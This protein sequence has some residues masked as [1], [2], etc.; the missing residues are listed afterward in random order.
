MSSLSSTDSWQRKARL[1]RWWARAQQLALCSPRISSSDR[2][3]SRISLHAAQQSP[4]TVVN[5]DSQ[6]SH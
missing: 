2:K 1:S 4:G 3:T 6:A 5:D